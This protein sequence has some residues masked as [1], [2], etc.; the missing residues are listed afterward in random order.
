MANMN[1]WLNQIEQG[2]GNSTRLD[3]ASAKFATEYL[4]NYVGDNKV[5]VETFAKEVLGENKELPESLKEKFKKHKIITLDDFKAELKNIVP[6][7]KLA[8]YERIAQQMSELQPERVIKLGEDKTAVARILTQGQVQDILNGGHINN[9]EFLKEFYANALGH[10]KFMDNDKY[11]FVPQ[12]TFD[13]LKKDLTNY[14][15]SIVEQAQKTDAK[16]VTSK[17]LKKASKHN[18]KMNLINWGSGFAV[19]ALFLSTLIPKMQY[20]ITKMRTGQDGFPG[21]EEYRQ[22]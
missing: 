2:K 8:D 15:K 12:S 3:P 10:R 19:S 14:V 11:K 20:W 4:N 16:E 22:G 7:D 18:F 9:P 5:D 17:L 6:A 1:S 13:S 21:T